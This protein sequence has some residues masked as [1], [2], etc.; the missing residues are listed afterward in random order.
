MIGP[1]ASVENPPRMEGRFLSMILVPN[2]EAVAEA[3]R[4]ATRAQ[5][6]QKA[7]AAAEPAASEGE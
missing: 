6:E 2:R 3:Q 7:E 1:L 5:Q 4:E